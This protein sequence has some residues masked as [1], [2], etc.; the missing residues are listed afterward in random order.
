MARNWKSDFPCEAYAKYGYLCR[1]K[2]SILL[3]TYHVFE[4]VIDLFPS[5]LK[6]SE[7]FIISMIF[8]STIDSSLLLFPKKKKKLSSLSN[9][10]NKYNSAITTTIN[11]SRKLKKVE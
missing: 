1:K 5:T 4:S 10:L 11:R 3:V 2:I 7:T 8:A 6:L 9:S